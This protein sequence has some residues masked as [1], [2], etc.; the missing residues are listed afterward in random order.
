MSAQEEEEEGKK[1]V[2]VVGSP[3]LLGIQPP[4]VH[5]KL[6]VGGVYPVLH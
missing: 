4:L 1:P 2:H 3:G 6:M 5:T